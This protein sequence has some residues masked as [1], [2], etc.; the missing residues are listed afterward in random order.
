LTPPAS[1]T[2]ERHR[3][4]LLREALA[5][6]APRPGMAV[7]DATVGGGGHAGALLE[8]TAPDGALLG[9]DRDPAALETARARLARFGPRV[10]LVEGNFSDLE[11]HLRAAGFGPA[12]AILA[13][14]GLSSLQLD[15]ATRGFSFRGD[16]PLDMRMSPS[17]PRTA[18]DIVNREPEAA[19]A[20]LFYAYGEERASRRIARRIVERRRERPF[21]RTSDLA[22]AVARAA[23]GRRG[24]IHPAT[25]VFQALRI[26]VNGELEALERLLASAPACL[27][28]GGRLA[29]IAFHSLEDRIVKRAFRDGAREGR[30]RILTPKPVA[31]GGA[32]CADNPRA[33]SAKL[34]CAEFV[35]PSP[36][37]SG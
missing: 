28:S 7:V 19:L 14:C 37:Q 27:V 10:R 23:G 34:R 16:G 30:W 35:M 13:D 26:A 12:G 8:A 21:E 31:P 9:I 6:L 33:R 2:I 11:A 32:E 22:E 15:D 36:V 18:A 4:V 1:G 20:D 29:V 3:P 17:D 5:L 25:R 24:R